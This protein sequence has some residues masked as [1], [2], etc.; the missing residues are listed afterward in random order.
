M[1]LNQSN[2]LDIDL[3]NK[4]IIFPTDTVYGIGC[5]LEDLEAVRRIY[6]IKKR[7]Y[8]KPMAI[9]CANLDEV[10]RVVEKET[11][12]LEKHI[13]HWPGKLTLIY[14]KS[15]QI[16]D[17]ITAGKISV[18]VRIPNHEISLKL[19]EKFGPMV[20]TSLNLSTEPAILKFEDVLHFQEVVDYIVD[21]GDLNSQ[22]STVYDTTTNTTLR[23]GDIVID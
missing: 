11:L 23:Q 15:N 16:S 2:Y 9:L 5:L 17:L 1:I 12:L 3:K 20:V 14:P 8:S 10:R 21:G 6:E 18:G 7:D 22:S 13:K 4:V 19:L